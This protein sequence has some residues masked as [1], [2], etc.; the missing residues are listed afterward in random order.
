MG[1]KFVIAALLHLTGGDFTR[2][3]SAPEPKV[4]ECDSIP[5]CREL[6]TDCINKG[7]RFTSG[8]TYGSDGLP[9]G[10]KG[11]CTTPDSYPKL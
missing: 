6:G 5:S 9:N 4:E 11:S 1:I 10:Y 7:G 8:P 3:E 2:P